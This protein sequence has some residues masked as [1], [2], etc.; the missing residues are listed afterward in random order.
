MEFL[1][2]PSYVKPEQRYR[3]AFNMYPPKFP[4]LPSVEFGVAFSPPFPDWFV[5][6]DFI[7]ILRQESLKKAKRVV[8][9]KHKL[10]SF[11]GHLHIGIED[12]H[13]ESEIYEGVKWEVF[14]L[15]HSFLS[16]RLYFLQ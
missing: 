12:A 13:V 5:Y 4:R 7:K 8:S 6:E 10:D 1:K 14:R 16:L 2:L 9:T 15:T 3:I 11:K